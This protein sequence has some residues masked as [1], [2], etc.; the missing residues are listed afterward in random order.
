MWRLR[1]GELRHDPLLFRIQG[2][3]DLVEAVSL[4]EQ[5]PLSRVHGHV[6]GRDG[7][8]GRWNNESSQS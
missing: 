5:A 1:A 8:L 3:N 6:V 7:H 2:E 4:G